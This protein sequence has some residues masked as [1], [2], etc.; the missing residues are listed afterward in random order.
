LVQPV[1]VRREDDL[2]PVSDNQKN[3]KKQGK[4]Q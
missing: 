2:K 1:V 4:I 3:Q